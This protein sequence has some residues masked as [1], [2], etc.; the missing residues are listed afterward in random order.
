MVLVS[1]RPLTP[2]SRVT[3]SQSVKLASGLSPVP[4]GRMSLVTGKTSGNS[5]SGTAVEVPSSQ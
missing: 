3:S 4:E 1:R 5:V 2:S